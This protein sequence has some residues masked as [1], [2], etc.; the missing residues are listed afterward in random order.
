[1][2]PT[3]LGVDVCHSLAECQVDEA[4]AQ[5]E[6]WE[7]NEQLPQRGTEPEQHLRKRSEAVRGVGAEVPL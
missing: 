6:V 1:M 5:A 7:D 2:L 3:K 4:P